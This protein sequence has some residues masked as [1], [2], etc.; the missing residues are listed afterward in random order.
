MSLRIRRGGAG[1]TPPPPPPPP[2]NVFG[3]TDGPPWVRSHATPQPI[4]VPPTAIEFISEADLISKVA[5]NASNTNFKSLPGANYAWTTTFQETTKSPNIYWLPGAIIDGQNNSASG[6]TGFTSE[7]G[8]TGFQMYGGEFKNFWRVFSMNGNCILE[9][10]VIHDCYEKGF[11][12]GGNNNRVSRTVVSA[13]GRYG[14]NANAASGYAT[15]N[16]IEFVQAYGNLTRA[17]D[18]R[19]DAGCSKLLNQDGL[20][21]RYCWIHDNFGAGLWWDGNN[22]NVQVLENVCENNLLW[23]IFYELG[24]GGTNIYN[25]AAFGNATGTSDFGTGQILTSGADATASGS[26]PYID[27]YNNWVDGDGTQV[28]IGVMNHTGHGLAKGT[29]YHDNDVFDHGTTLRRM[30]GVCSTNGTVPLTDDN[31]FENNHYH[32]LTGQTGAQKFVFG[33]DQNVGQTFAQW[34][35]AGRDDTGTMV[36]I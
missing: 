34:Q 11:N 24:F 6:I 33:T 9:D 1:G 30:A 12:F 4:T 2:P 27:I 17:L 22:R 23:G 36:T 10:A 19:V 18:P 5:A 25:N 35:T 21:V 26:T 8:S 29:H 14:F 31:T 28:Q 16:V 32:V 13:C 7:P 3:P 20:I 15:G